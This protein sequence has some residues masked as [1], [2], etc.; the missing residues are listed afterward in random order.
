MILIIKT[1]PPAVTG[2]RHLNHQF[3]QTYHDYF[4]I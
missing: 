1:L 4:S 3:P 2:E